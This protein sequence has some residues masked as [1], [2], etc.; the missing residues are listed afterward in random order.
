MIMLSFRNLIY[1]SFL[2]ILSFLTFSF[3]AC[4]EIN[5]VGRNVVFSVNNA[6]PAPL[7]VEVKSSVEQEVTLEQ[8]Y[9]FTLWVDGTKV[10][11]TY[12]SIKGETYKLKTGIYTAHAQ[13]CAPEFAEA[14]PDAYGSVR[15]YGSTEFEVETLKTT[16]NVEINCSIANSRVAVVI[17][18][19]F[20]DNFVKEETSVFIS[21]VENMSS[22]TLE[23]I[24]AGAQTVSEGLRTAYFTA[25]DAVYAE[26]TTR[27]K[28]SDRS[29]TYRVKA[30]ASAQSN[31][32]YTISLSANENSTS[33]GITFIVSGNEMTT[34]DYLSIENYTP[35]T[36]FVEDN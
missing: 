4:T 12:G 7:A 23:M 30:V 32:S 14:N 25:G 36:D 27:K 35:A 11:G 19:D 5:E 20:A 18:D 34:N 33:G 29:V 15:Y 22:R 2:L 31:T 26:V 17:S 24:S 3:V 10:S 8:I 6:I 28:G 16:Q 21:D 13:S 9:A 1:K